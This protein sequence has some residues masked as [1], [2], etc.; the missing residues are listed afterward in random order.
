M[1]DKN[2]CI[3]KMTKEQTLFSALSMDLYPIIVSISYFPYKSY[4]YFFLWKD[5][6]QIKENCV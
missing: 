6:L 3:G 4:K 2:Y 5:D 1:D